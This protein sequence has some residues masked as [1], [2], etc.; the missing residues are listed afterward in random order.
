MKTYKSVY[1]IVFCLITIFSFSQSKNSQFFEMQGNECKIFITKG[2]SRIIVPSNCFTLDGKPYNGKIKITFREYKDQIDFILGGL[3]M[4]YI[5]NGKLNYLQSGGMF[6]IFVNAENNTKSELSFAQNKTITV[7][8]AIDKKFDVAGLEPFYYD[9]KLKKWTK[10]TR[11]GN[12]SK[13]NKPISDNQEDLWQDDPRIITQDGGDFYNGDNDCYTILVADKND[14]SKFVDSLICP[15]NYS[16]LDS[17]YNQY[18]D[19]QAFKT[20]QIDM[21]GLYNYD[22]IFNEENSIPLFVNLKTKDGKKLEITDR[23]FVVYKNSNSTIYYYQHDID[24]NFKLIPRND[25]KVFVYNADGTI[26]KV[27]DDFWN[28]IEI[29][30]LRGKKIDLVFE[31]LKMSTIS[32]EQFALVTGIK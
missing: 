13:S 21:M 7:K 9:K 30:T 15:G 11:F 16:I 25:I 19:D 23:L 4:R 6:E 17:R 27:P 24:S 1:T 2:N 32:K 20:M 3:D 26:Y 10:I 29:K 8:F 31:K 18:L 14:P 28:N 12:D 22:K 5:V